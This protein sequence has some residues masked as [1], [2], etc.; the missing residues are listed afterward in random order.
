MRATPQQESEIGTVLAAFLQTVSYEVG[1]LP[2]YGRLLELFRP[3]GVLV[4][5]GG[6]D[7]PAWP[8]RRFV[9]DREQAL[10][11]GRQTRFV[12]QE[13]SSCTDVFGAVAHR[14]SVY[15]KSGVLDGEPFSARGVIS[16]QLVHAQGRW[17][18]S[19]M[20]WDDERPGVALPE[21]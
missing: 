11:Q 6:E 17:Q 9:A 18:I 3:D 5:A 20:V 7:P 1:E 16:T 12:E 15:A 10:A 13:Q 14:L 8:V 19:S 21:E 2:A 4:R